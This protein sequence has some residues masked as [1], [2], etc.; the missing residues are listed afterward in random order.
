MTSMGLLSWEPL[1][2]VLVVAGAATLAVVLLYLFPTFQEKWSRRQTER[3]LEEAK[4]GADAAARTSGAEGANATNHATG[5][6][7]WAC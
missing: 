4:Q 7:L 3:W 5:D 1:W 6:D 2:P